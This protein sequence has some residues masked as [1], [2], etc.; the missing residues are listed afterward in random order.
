[1]E[2]RSTDEDE[3]EES[4]LCAAALEKLNPLGAGSHNQGSDAKLPSAEQ[5]RGS[6]SWWGF[7]GIPQTHIP[8]LSLMNHLSSP[9][10]QGPG[11]SPKQPCTF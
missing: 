11:F 4:R 2:N 3:T 1:M 5:P 10:A 7:V 9:P 8:F 6:Q